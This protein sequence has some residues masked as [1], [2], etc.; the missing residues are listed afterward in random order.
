MNAQ[1]LLQ[2]ISDYCRQSGLAESTFGR[3]AVNDGKLTSRLRNGGRI[4][5]ETLDR[6]R[7]FMHANVGMQGERPMVI[8]RMRPAPVLAA[9]APS[10]RPAMSSAAGTDPAG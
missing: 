1:E 4:T 10:P 5:T 2:E 3:R 9:S 7:N 6:I 8:E